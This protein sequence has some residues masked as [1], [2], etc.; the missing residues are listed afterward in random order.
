MS[1]KIVDINKLINLKEHTLLLLELEDMLEGL[2][3]EEILEILESLD[4][5]A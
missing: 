1:K 4:E 2:S 5:S 3:E